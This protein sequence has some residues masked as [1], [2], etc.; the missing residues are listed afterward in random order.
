[1]NERS[2]SAAGADVRGPSGSPCN[3]SAPQPAVFAPGEGHLSEQEL[4]ALSPREILWRHRSVAGLSDALIMMVDDQPRNVEM[5]Q[6][7]LA[8]VGYRRFVQAGDPREAIA[9][10]RSERPGLLLLDL[11]PDLAGMDLLAALRD[12][13]ELRHVPVVFL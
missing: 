2:A 8:E 5:T 4:K 3:Q 12:D 1:M 10:M 13:P 9:L 7:F 6:A 11:D